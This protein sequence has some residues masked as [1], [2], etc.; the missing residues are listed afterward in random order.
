MI[1]RSYRFTLF[2]R[3]DFAHCSVRDEDEIFVLWSCSE[4]FIILH[5][6]LANTQDVYL[7]IFIIHLGLYSKLFLFRVCF[8]N[9]HSLS[10]VIVSTPFSPSSLVILTGVQIV[11]QMPEISRNHVIRHVLKSNLDIKPPEPKSI[12]AHSSMRYHSLKMG[13]W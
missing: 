3:A 2:K 13:S 8:F 5:T 12:F 9:F 11:H 6:L 4:S 1:D 10:I 7:K